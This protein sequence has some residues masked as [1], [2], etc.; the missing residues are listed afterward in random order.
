MPSLMSASSTS[1]P[2][3]LPGDGYLQP[4]RYRRYILVV[5]AIVLFALPVTAAARSGYEVHA[6]GLKLVLPVR[7]SAKY[8][9][10][11]S[12]N[13]QQR[14]KFVVNGPFSTT[15]YSTEGYVSSRRLVAT[16]GSL[17][18]VDVKLHFTRNFSEPSHNGHCKGR[19]SRYQEGTYRGVLEF[20]QSGDTPTISHTHGRLYFTHRF[21]QVCK[22]QQVG[23][24]G[25]SKLSRETEVGFLAVD[26]ETGG[27]TVLLEALD[28][29]LKRKPARSA[30]SLGVEIYEGR[31]GVRITRKRSV[32]TDHN[33]F[34]MSK[35]GD[36]PETVEVDPPAPFIGRALY[37]SGPGSSSSWTGDLSV[38]LSGVGMV[39]LTGPAFSA[40][41]C[42]SSFIASY[43]DC[44]PRHQR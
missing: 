25:N 12:A 20:S 14:V 10:S 23:A 4:N 7:H 1:V 22:R 36:V 13:E 21:K 44:A 35:R 29:A 41:L 17:G 28:L 6:G 27:R 9:I 42:R 3:S 39:P 8:V 5:T 26:G 37:S 16:F 2:H 19:G 24:G 43:E 31:E 32:L 34:I 11:V 40:S 33:S 18:R 15:E 38:H 30:G